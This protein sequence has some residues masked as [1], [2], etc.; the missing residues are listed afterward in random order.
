MWHAA[1]SAIETPRQRSSPSTRIDGV[2]SAAQEPDSADV[3]AE[4]EG[5]QRRFERIRRRHLPTTSPYSGPCD[6]RVGRFCFWHGPGRDP[7]A[8]RAAVTEAREALLEAL[9]RAAE[10]LPGDGWIAGQRVRYR[11]EAGRPDAAVAAAEACRSPEPGWCAA[12]LGYARHAASDFGG[13]D[14]AFAAALAAMPEEA[15]CAWTDLTLL[16]EGEGQG[17]YEALE[18]AERESFERTFWRLADPLWGL[19]G[20]ERRTEHYARHVLDRLQ[21]GADSGYGVRWGD[22]LRELL[23]RYGWPAGFEEVRRSYGLSP[24]GRPDVIA[25]DFPHARRYV[26]SAEALASP[27]PPGADAWSVEPRRPRSQFAALHLRRFHP[28]RH[29]VGLFRRGEDLLLVAAYD[30]PASRDTAA[31]CDSVVAALGAAPIDSEAPWGPR[32]GR[33][34]VAVEPEAAERGAVRLR[35]V[36]SRGAGRT[37]DRGVGGAGDRGRGGTADRGA[38]GTAGRAAG[39]EDTPALLISVEARC[40]GRAEAARARGRIAI[41]PGPALAHLGLSDLLLLEAGEPLPATLEEA[42]E[43]ALPDSRVRSGEPFVVYW[44]LYRPGD[45]APGGRLDVQIALTRRDGPG[46][47]R[48]VLEWTGLAAD[49]PE[50]TGL[51]WT[52]RVPDATRA[53]RAV[54][55]TLPELP[56][57]A[58]RLELEVRSPGADPVVATRELRVER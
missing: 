57:G 17:A 29:Q 22:D 31:A 15:R 23:L 8:E 13:A 11:A 24:G 21:E 49:R 4:A 2:P 18:C 14:L 9:D 33:P 52:E 19:P 55:L 32:L 10:A 35:L 46:F 39:P 16:L 3:R 50:G 38:G 27:P 45:R 6:E 44:E 37:D 54:T 26:P 34:A 51:R 7:P 20:N 43:R 53:P 28:L 47:F 36:A 56:A 42:A 25:Y 1:D 30:L 58:Y 48:R 5:A 40:P 41:P 12:L